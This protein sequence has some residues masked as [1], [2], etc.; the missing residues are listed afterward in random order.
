MKLALPRKPMT[1]PEVNTEEFEA[2][3]AAQS[4]PVPE[5]SE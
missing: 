5:E 4:M 1:S 2:N 3:E